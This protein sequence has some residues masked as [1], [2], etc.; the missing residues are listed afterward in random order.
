MKRTPQCSSK[1]WSIATALLSAYLLATTPGHA[2][3]FYGPNEYLQKG[4]QQ[5]DYAPEFDW[6]L[7]VKRISREFRPEGGPQFRDAVFSRRHPT[8]A[9]ESVDAAN[10]VPAKM[11]VTADEADFEA[12]IKEGRIKPPDPAAARAQHSAMRQALGAAGATASPEFASEFADYHRGAFAYRLGSAGYDD[13]RKAWEALLARPAAERHYRTV[14]ATFM[15]GKLAMKQGSPDAPAWF[16]KTRAFA[17]EGFA[18]SLGM[19][20][21]SYGWEGRSEWKLGHPEKAARLFLTQLALGDESAVVSLKA[22]IP[23]RASVEGMLNYG[24][25]LETME[26]WTDVDKKAAEKKE[27]AGLQK[28]AADPLLRRLETLHILATEV[29]FLPET[30]VAPIAPKVDRIARW[31]KILKDAKITQTEDAE[32]LGWA[33][34]QRG[35]Y[36]TAEQ[37]LD[38]AKKESGVGLW[39][40]AKLQRRAG[41]QE[42][43]AK[44][45]VDAWKALQNATTYTGWT[46]PPIEGGKPA[47]EDYAELTYS[48]GEEERWGFLERAGGDL[49]CL[50]LARGEFLQAFEAFRKGGLWEDAA[51]I[52]ESI[53]TTE[54]LKAFVDHEAETQP[55]P[56]PKPV[57][58][59]PAEKAE[60]AEPPQKTPGDPESLR[61]LLGRRLVREDRY[62]EAAAYLPPTYKKVLE[63]YAKALADGANEKLEKNA[64]A[65]AWFKAAWV[66]RYSGLEIMG[67][68]TA[69]DGFLFDGQFPFDPIAQDR[70]TGKYTETV[71]NQKAGKEVTS[72]KPIA[73][74]ATKEEVDR[75]TKNRISPD[76]RWHYRVIAGILAMKAAALLPDNAPE[77]GDVINTA[78]RWVADRDNK[79]ADADFAILMKRAAKTEIGKAA[80]AKR[81]FVDMTGPWSD[82]ESAAHEELLK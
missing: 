66:A 32:Y 24:P 72:T 82:R 58:A 46:A 54:E 64:R 2:T 56:K 68:E 13:A 7:E 41:K 16:Q 65:A 29:G 79:A 77:L 63:V 10:E 43:A 47:E 45:M 30:D 75:L 6:E 39:L 9:P 51:F 48:Q 3:G 55:P 4:A 22:I 42:E 17:K 50:K 28:A 21:D 69:P 59:K 78:G 23:D 67:T 44:S 15:L 25:E 34:Y 76:V 1:W 57:E 8:D 5:I 31:L 74:K 52:A 27:L 20:A 18:D 61:W 14:W 26:K 33:S 40:R 36:K 62:V 73:L 60:E 19:A 12:A 71:Y 35:D 81:W 37:L 80:K 53:L 11:T 49:A 38:L 70:R